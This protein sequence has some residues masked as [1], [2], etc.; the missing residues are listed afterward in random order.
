MSPFNSNWERLHRGLLRGM[1][2][3]SGGELPMEGGRGK[4]PRSGNRPPGRLPATGFPTAPRVHG[5]PER[6]G[7]SCALRGGSPQSE[8]RRPPLS[9]CSRRQ[10]TEDGRGRKVKH[11]REGGRWVGLLWEPRKTRRG[12]SHPPGNGDGLVPDGGCADRG[13][14]GWSPAGVHGVRGAGCSREGNGT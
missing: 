6:T 8:C 7:L 11:R 3:V 14:A 9:R 1:S 13:L 4:W 5:L 12:Q 10:N 2:P